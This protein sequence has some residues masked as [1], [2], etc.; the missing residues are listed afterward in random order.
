MSEDPCKFCS[1]RTIPQS[2]NLVLDSIVFFNQKDLRLFGRSNTGLGGRCCHLGANS[3]SGSEGL[4][5]ELSLECCATGLDGEQLSL[6]SIVQVDGSEGD[7]VC[8]GFTGVGEVECV[9]D[10]F[11]WCC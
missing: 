10:D 8:D 7:S 11:C 2:Q 1:I 3:C 4:V 6:A 5:P 9:A